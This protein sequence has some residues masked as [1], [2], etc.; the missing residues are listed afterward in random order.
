MG[1]ST[2]G[3]FWRP[4]AVRGRTVSFGLHFSG[5]AASRVRL[6]GLL[7]RDTSFSLVVTVTLSDLRSSAALLFDLGF[8][9]ADLL[10][11]VLVLLL[12]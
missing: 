8:P 9:E 5:G 3:S 10:C 7:V 12:L 1:V 11:A 4:S 6:S 2:T